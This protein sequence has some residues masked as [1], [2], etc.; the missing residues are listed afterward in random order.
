MPA[1]NSPRFVKEIGRTGGQRIYDLVVK[2]NEGEVK[3]RDNRILIVTW[4]AGESALRVGRVSRQIVF[5]RL[6][7]TDEQ[8]DAVVSVEIWI[9]IRSIRI[10]RIKIV[11][12]RAEVAQSIR[13][14]VALEFRIRIKRDVMVNELTEIGEAGGNIWIVEIRI[15]GLRLRFDHQCTQRQKI[16]IIWSEGWKVA[17]HSSKASFVESGTRNIFKAAYRQRSVKT[18]GGAGTA[19]WWLAREFYF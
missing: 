19:V 7:L 8:M 18:A 13:I 3:L 14:V 1:H 6:V 4:I 11:A 9:I 12:G 2:L 5:A 17:I 15:V 10:Q 16:R